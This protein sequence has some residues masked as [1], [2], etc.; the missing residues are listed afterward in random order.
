[1][2]KT[3]S[4]ETTNGLLRGHISRATDS[5]TATGR[6]VR[7]ADVGS[8]G[9]VFGTVCRPDVDS[10]QPSSLFESLC[11]LPNRVLR[12]PPRKRNPEPGGVCRP[13]SREGS[14]R[15]TAQ[16]NSPQFPRPRPKSDCDWTLPPRG[17]WG[18]RASFSG[19][20]TLRRTTPHLSLRPVRFY[21]ESYQWPKVGISRP[22]RIV[23]LPRVSR[24][25]TPT[26]HPTFPCSRGKHGGEGKRERPAMPNG[27]P[28]EHLANQGKTD[29]K[30]RTPQIPCY[31]S[32]F[33]KIPACASFGGQ[34][35]HA[36]ESRPPTRTPSQ[37]S[38]NGEA[39]LFPF[40]E[41]RNQ[42]AFSPQLWRKHKGLGIASQR[43]GA[44]RKQGPTCMQFAQPRDFC[45]NQS[46]GNLPYPVQENERVGNISRCSRRGTDPRAFSMWLVTYPP[47]QC[48]RAPGNTDAAESVGE[49]KETNSH[50]CISNASRSDETNALRVGLC[51]RGAS[52]MLAQ[53]RSSTAGSLHVPTWWKLQ[54]HVRWVF[55]TWTRPVA[56]SQPAGLANTEERS[57]IPTRKVRYMTWLQSQAGSSQTHAQV[58]PPET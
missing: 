17:P 40:P 11:G 51:F 7:A 24:L 2:A 23:C 52:I 12:R 27:R 14:W 43:R 38:T 21:S 19:E 49:A 8:P 53:R 18:G 15:E 30:K 29:R 36:R 32:P 57:P 28:Q 37:N 22:F 5:L 54:V 31:L 26:R 45:R 33:L 10:G 1:M 34:E 13:A 39:R 20:L 50:N 6:D 46:R 48:R 9:R 47:V 3:I 16:Q 35:V 41:P 56:N 25:T 55:G 42:M 4:N 58:P 44:K